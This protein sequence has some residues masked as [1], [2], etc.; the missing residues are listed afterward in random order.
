MWWRVLIGAAAGLMVVW[1]ALVGVRWRAQRHSP[2]TARLRDVVRLV[3]LM[4]DLLCL[5]QSGK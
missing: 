4:V 2:D 3:P 1:V 5:S